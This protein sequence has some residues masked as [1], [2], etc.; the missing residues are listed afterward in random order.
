MNSVIQAAQPYITALA[1][2]LIGLLA[3]FLLAAIAHLKTKLSA[4][5]TTRASADQRELLHKL[6]AEAYA[7]AEQQ[8]AG[9]YGDEK[10]AAALQYV[11]ARLKLDGAITAEDI[12]AAIQKAWA[13]LDAKNR[14]L[15]S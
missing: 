5:L 10:M 3:T 14:R 4:W 1:T 9:L 15:S 8:Y 12:T 11:L 7:F 2:A 13:E 6:A